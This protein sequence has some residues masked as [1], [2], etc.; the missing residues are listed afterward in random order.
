VKILAQFPGNSQE[1]G[2]PLL[3]DIGAAFDW[4]VW[5]A[6]VYGVPAICLAAFCRIVYLIFK[7]TKKPKDP[8]DT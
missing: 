7:D 6:M 1:T 2:S 4:L 8:S 3:N 5:H